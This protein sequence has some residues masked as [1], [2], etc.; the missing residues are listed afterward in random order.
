MF[1]YLRDPCQWCWTFISAFNRYLLRVNFV[2]KL[3][4]ESDILCSYQAENL[5]TGRQA[6]AK[7]HLKHNSGSIH[8]ARGWPKGDNDLGGGGGEN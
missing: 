2:P 7:K 5:E 3:W 4:R 8:E 1:L 6:S